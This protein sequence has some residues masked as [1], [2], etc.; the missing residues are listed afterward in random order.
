MGPTTP[1]QQ[2]YPYS[3][4]SEAGSGGPP[5]ISIQQ[6]T[7]QHHQFMSGSNPNLPGALLPGN[8][9]R[10]VPSSTNTAPSVVPTLP[11]IATQSQQP[12]T[13]SRSST[14]NHSHGHSQSSPAGF[15]QPKY[16]QYT[17]TPDHPKYSSPP[18]SGYPTHTPMGAKYS[19]L[20][21]ADI[22]P[23]AESLLVDTSTQQNSV[24]TNGD[25]LVPTNSNYVAPWPIYA[26]DWCKWTMPSA[27]S[28]AGKIALGSYLEDSHNYVS[29]GRTSVVCRYDILTIEIRFKLST[30][31]DR[32]QTL[33]RQMSHLGT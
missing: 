18:A 27:G 33:T 10:P 7:P 32:S 3:A 1:R 29:L 22:R 13:P 24:P 2:S 6:S 14:I 11:Q 9:H 16:K 8:T 25:L 23:S 20:G 17:N 28:F 21:L 19:P 15:E 4:G 30:L 26:V 31:I 12:S 5:S